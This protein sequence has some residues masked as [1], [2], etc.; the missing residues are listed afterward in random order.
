MLIEFFGLTKVVSAWKLCIAV[1]D[2]KE[3][4]NLKL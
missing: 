2:A 3:L 1:F 4:R